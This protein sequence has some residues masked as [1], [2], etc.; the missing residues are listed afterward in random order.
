MAERLAEAGHAIQVGRLDQARRM[1]SA[2]VASGAKGETVDR[3]LADLAYA[4]RNSDEALARYKVL[5]GLHPNDG[6]TLERAAI[7]AVRVGEVALAKGLTDHAVSLPGASWR[8]WNARG[9]VADLM[10]DFDKADSSYRRALELAPG[11]AEILNNLGW[12]RLLRGDWAGAL[13][14]LEEA[15]KLAPKNARVANNVELAKA[16]LAAELPERRP[17]ESEDEWAMRLND[18]G[19][20]ARLQGDRARA[21]AAFA[22]AIEARG[23]WYE[24]AANNLRAAGGTE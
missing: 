8:S 14:P 2:A 15:A 10:R 3:L 13:A 22:Q 19:V 9:V 21:I 18:A 16:A 6:S 1:I 17:G 12:S 4:S 23:S 5:V 11:Q 7:S 20:V 24:R